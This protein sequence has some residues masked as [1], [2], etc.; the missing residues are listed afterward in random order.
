MKFD[1]NGIPTQVIPYQR[2][3]ATDMIEEFMLLANETVAKHFYWLEIPFVY[4]VHDEP[5][6]DKMKE[7]SMFLVKF[8]Y[9]IKVAGGKIH[10]K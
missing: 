4:R 1:D 6:P 9:S 8:G 10:P 3:E 7:L 5:D 2:N